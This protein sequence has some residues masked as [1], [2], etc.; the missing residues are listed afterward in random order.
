MPARKLIANDKAARGELA[1][2]DYPVKTIGEATPRLHLQLRVRGE[3]RTWRVMWRWG[4]RIPVAYGDRTRMEA[5]RK[6]YTLGPL[7]RRGVDGLT[8][9]AAIEAASAVRERVKRGEDPRAVITTADDTFADAIAGWLDKAKA[10][11]RP[12]TMEALEGAARRLTT[13]AAERRVGT[14][15]D[16]NR[17]HLSDFRD[18]LVKLPRQAAA[19]KGKRGAKRVA[20]E[21]RSPHTI[22]RE[23]RGVKTMLGALRKGGK[24]PHLDRDA[25]ADMD[26][27]AT[28]RVKP[29][30]LKTPQIAKLLRACDR[31]DAETFALTREG[32]TDTPRHE[33]IKPLVVFLLLTG[34]RLGEAL[35]LP[36]S[37]VDLDTTTPDGNPIG[38]IELRADDVKTGSDR[39]IFLNVCPTVRGM[40]AAMRLASGGD[41]LVWAGYTKE[42]AAKARKRLTESYGAPAFLW[43][44]QNRRG[45]KRSPP[46]LRATCA[47]YLH[48]AYG[49]YGG[50]ALHLASAQL[51]HSPEV[52]RKHYASA[53]TSIPRDAATLEAAMRIEDLLAG[54]APGERLRGVM[55][56]PRTA[57]H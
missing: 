48:C 33:P 42:I 44:T 17:E 46:T 4:T 7:A 27:L 5:P 6:R 3:T 54:L 2:G 35:T 18:W 10:T 43:S 20:G 36:W 19:P 57:P 53:E 37:Q 52:A 41:G 31:H 50:G 1:D 32:A 26:L 14:I 15:A 24:L 39:T 16:L 13:W 40:L 56:T 47:T 45:G 12:K 29:S 30:R 55:F 23:I 49:I 38:E 22:N 34:M 25:I 9:K 51:G 21:T 8:R 28:P 11:R